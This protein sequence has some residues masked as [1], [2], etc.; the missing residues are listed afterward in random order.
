MGG[1][2]TSEASEAAGG[3]EHSF[4]RDFSGSH[5]LFYVLCST[6]FLALVL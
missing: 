1:N 3:S 4:T 2:T 5:A 6:C